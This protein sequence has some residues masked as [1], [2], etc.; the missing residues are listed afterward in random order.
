MH[1]EKAAEAQWGRF[2]GKATWQCMQYGRRGL[3][4]A[5]RVII[6]NELGILCTSI[7]AQQDVKSH[8]SLREVKVIMRQRSVRTEMEDLPPMDEIIGQQ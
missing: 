3:I 5:S 2:N 7:Q 8:F 6:K 4:P 1:L